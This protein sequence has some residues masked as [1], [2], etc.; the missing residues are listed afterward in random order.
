MTQETKERVYNILVILLALASVILAVLDLTR[1]LSQALIWS[2]RVIYAFFVVEY[3]V[4][5]IK[6][7]DKGLFFKKNILDLIAILP[8]NSI[9]R[10]FRIVRVARAARLVRL[11]RLAAVFTRFRSRSRG[12]L[13]T[14]GLKYI[15]LISF[16]VIVVSS[17]IMTKV[18]HM[19]FDDALWWSLVTVTTVGYGDLSP[20]T[21]VGRGV[22]VVLMLVGI[23]L[24]GS[25]SST[26]TSY[27]LH[28]KE[29]R[30][31]P[32]SERVEMVMTLYDSLTP[33]EKLE[34]QA[35]IDGKS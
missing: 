16:C 6:A 17:V 4:R 19:A 20:T 1:G 22:A 5:L 8:F 28:P 34:F 15:L 24:I 21:D 18:E 23:G 26:L 2:D 11:I 14:N 30:R 29:K 27:F 32:S 3:V 12:L 31:P 9:L 10:G 7:E 35:Q 33:E 25:L 13:N